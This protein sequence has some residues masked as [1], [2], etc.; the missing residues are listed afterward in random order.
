[1]T[2]RDALPHP[3]RIAEIVPESPDTR[4]FVLAPDPPLAALDAARPGQFVML[5][6]LGHGEAAFTLSDLPPWGAAPGTAVVTVRRVGRLTSALFALEAGAR[7]GA[8]GPFGRGFPDEP[9]E[10]TLYVAGGCGLSPLKA[11]ITRQIHARPDGTSLV[12]LYG[13]RDPEARIHRA[14]LAAWERA[15]GVCLIECVERPGPGWRG[16]VGVVVDCLDEAIGRIAARR[17][18]VCGPPPMLPAVAERLVRAG[19]EPA[20]IHLAVER[21]MKCGTGHCGHC[22]VDH[23][24]VCTDGP[25][26][27]YAELRGLTDA[28]RSETLETGPAVC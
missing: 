26:F 6:V 14:A 20:H 19:L 5:S 25:V 28:F 3:A 18:A 24:Y 7:V 1:M 11:A 4:T 16:R 21:Y 27:P 22:Y 2:F 12:I 10:P 17:A 15:A 9:D 23:R 13:A 8:R